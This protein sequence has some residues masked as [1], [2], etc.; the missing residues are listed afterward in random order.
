MSTDYYLLKNICPHCGKPE[1][2]IEIGRSSGGWCFGLRV[3]P[4]LGISYLDDWNRLFNNPANAI[5]DEYGERIAVERM[6]EIITARKWNH[7]KKPDDWYQ[8]NH[9]IKGPN[10]LVRHKIDGEFVIA[11]GS[12]T[13]DYIKGNSTLDEW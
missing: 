12:G 3:Y 1:K 13:Y 7:M 5:E 9:A 2:K 10:G 6:I 11:H 8:N 4:S